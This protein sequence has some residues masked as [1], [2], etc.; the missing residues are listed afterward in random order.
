MGG[1]G[2]LGAM[3]EMP[4]RVP[5]SVPSKRCGVAA[6][7]ANGNRAGT[8][9]V[10]TATPAADA[11]ATTVPGVLRAFDA[12]DVSGQLWNSEQN[13]SRDSLGDFA[14]FTVPIIANGGVYVAT[15]SNRLVVYGLAAGDSGR[16]AHP[17]ARRPRE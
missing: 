16:R 13:A 11:E 7:S 5:G 6:V 14:K 10:W 15:F 3:H 1:P 9:I 4:R 2:I 12:S 17:R 8:G